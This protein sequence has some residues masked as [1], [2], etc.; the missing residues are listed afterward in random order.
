MLAEHHALLDAFV[1][2]IAKA[3]GGKSPQTTADRV[4]A[5]RIR[6]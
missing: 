5:S 4:R 1:K 2:G 3:F 6:R